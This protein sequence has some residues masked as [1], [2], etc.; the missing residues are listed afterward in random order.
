MVTIAELKEQ[1]R[2]EKIKSE[3]ETDLRDRGLERKRLERELSNLKRRK[4]IMFFRAIGKGTSEVVRG[5][6]KVLTTIS[7]PPK[8]RPIK[9]LRRIDKRKP[10][11][12]SFDEAA[13]SLGDDLIP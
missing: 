10:K 9:K 13:M 7:K 3:Q 1:I 6:G 2:R 12:L 4:S 5:T 11:P 8:K